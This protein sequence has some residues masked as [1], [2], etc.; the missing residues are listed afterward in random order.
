MKNVLKCGAL[1]ATFILLA[2][3]PAHA[4]SGDTYSF[5]LSGPISA[6]WTLSENPTPTY[7]ESGT[8]FVVDATDLVVDGLAAPDMVVFF[9][10][11]DL[12]GLNS[13]VVLPD[14]I[15]PQIYTGDESDPTF[16][17]GTYYFTSWETGQEETLTV[18]KTPEPTTILLLF[19]GLGLLGL[20][21]KRASLNLQQ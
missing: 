19:S 1:L 21:R 2:V 20:K 16:Q 8:A 4:D 17:A 10:I 18:A 11:S 3:L 6:S 9:N 12:G 13:F 14:F 7:F 5:T 15:G